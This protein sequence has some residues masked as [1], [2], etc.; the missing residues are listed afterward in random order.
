MN[1]SVSTGQQVV[2][3]SD[4]VTRFWIALAAFTFVVGGFQTAITLNL[5]TL[6]TTVTAQ[7]VQIADLMS[8]VSMEREERIR[9]DGEKKTE[10]A[11]QDQAIQRNTQDIQEHTVGHQ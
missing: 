11:L 6:G 8:A 3:S 10:D 9:L 5:K 1:D 7:S 2:E 4:R